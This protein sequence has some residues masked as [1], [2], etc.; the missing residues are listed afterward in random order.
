M[1][2]PETIAAYRRM[3]EAGGTLD[4]PVECLSDEEVVERVEA[5]IESFAEM[6]RQITK[7]FVEMGQKMAEAFDHP[8]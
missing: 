2:D 3:L 4:R 6:A 8:G 1:N 7:A 5:I